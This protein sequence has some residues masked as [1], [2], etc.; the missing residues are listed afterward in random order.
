MGMVWYHIIITVIK[1]NMYVPQL[2]SA[3]QHTH[4]KIPH[5][6]QI[7]CDIQSDP[8]SVFLDIIAGDGK[9]RVGSF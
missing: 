7:M 1:Y 2:Q 4:T 6:T 9:S 5:F 8:P 3:T